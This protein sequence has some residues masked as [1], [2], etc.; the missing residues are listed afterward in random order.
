MLLRNRPLLIGL[1]LLFFL[2]QAS[3]GAGL[4]ASG[5]DWRPLWG[6]PIVRATMVDFTFTALWCAFY[7]LDTAKQQQRNGWAWLPLLLIFPTLAV[8]LFTLTAPREE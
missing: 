4:A 1:L 2:L 3:L 7:L 8:F 6:A 5:F